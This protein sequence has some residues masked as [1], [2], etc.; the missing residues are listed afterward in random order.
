VNHFHAHSRPDMAEFIPAN[1]LEIQIRAVLTDKNTPLW[2]FYTPLAATELYM[3][4]AAH[5]ELDGSDHIAP[6]GA[7]TPRCA[8]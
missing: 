5:P 8:S 4:T 3:I 1:S 7:A 2:S 6:G